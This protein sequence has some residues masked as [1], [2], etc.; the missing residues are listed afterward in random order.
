MRRLVRGADAFIRINTQL[1]QAA[2][3]CFFL[4]GERDVIRTHAPHAATPAAP[5]PSTG[6]LTLRHS[7]ETVRTCYLRYL[8]R[9]IALQAPLFRDDARVTQM[10][11]PDRLAAYSY[12]HLP[13]LFKAQGRICD[14]DLPS[15]S[16]KLGLTST[17][18]GCCRA[19]SSSDSGDRSTRLPP[20]AISSKCLPRVSVSSSMGCV[21][22]RSSGACPMATSRAVRKARCRPDG[23]GD[24]SL[25]WIKSRAARTAENL[26]R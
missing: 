25:I 1:S 6:G 12:A 4:T 9:E 8:R 18:P 15:A 11:W 23:E 5:R 2:T 24:D 10:H 22:P 3:A 20:R 7:G 21:S 17:T 19:W 13:A 26:R 14:S 16:V